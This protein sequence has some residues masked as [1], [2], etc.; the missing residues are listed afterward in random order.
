ML[1]AM[2][3]SSADVTALETAIKSGR[4]KVRYADGQE[5]TY[6][7]LA[8]MMELRRTMQAEIDSVSATGHVR[9]RH[10]LASFADD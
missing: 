8:G 4:L 10:Q 2:S 1:R 6:Q 3:F 7:S 5:I 9:P